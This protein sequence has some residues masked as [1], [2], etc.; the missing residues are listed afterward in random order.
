MPIT[1][2]GLD[3][4][5]RYEMKGRVL[6]KGPLVDLTTQVGLYVLLRHDK[7]VYIGR[8]SL[9]A[10]PG[11]SGRIVGHR[12]DKSESWSKYSWFGFYP[13]I[14]GKVE[15][16]VQPSV[17]IAE[18]ISDIEALGI[19]LLTSAGCSINK[20]VGKHRHMDE[21]YQAK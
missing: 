2:Y 3:W 6:G 12:Y 4:D 10:N 19:Y 5:D 13:V 1:C 11:I 9:G 18:A 21:Y 8:S 7:P 20:A 16:R 17:S 15:K 14:D